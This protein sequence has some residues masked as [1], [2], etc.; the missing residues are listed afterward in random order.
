[1]PGGAGMGPGRQPE[2]QDALGRRKDRLRGRLGELDGQGHVHEGERILDDVEA[3]GAPHGGGA[4]V[5]N[6][7]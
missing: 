5:I 1:M 3:F 7:C 6:C 4:S 2:G